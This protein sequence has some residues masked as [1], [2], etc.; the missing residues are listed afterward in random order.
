MRFILTLIAVMTALDVLWWAVA[1]RFV[2]GS[3]WQWFLGLFMAAQVCTILWFV[4]ARAARS[5]LDALL[6]QPAISALYIWHFIGLA[7]AL[8]I[9]LGMLVVLAA[10]G[11]RRL[12]VRSGKIAPEV[13]GDVCTRRRFIGIAAAVTPPLVTLGFTGLAAA[14]LS[15]FRV[16]R[17]EVPI[18]NLPRDLDG[19]SIAQVSDIHVG[20]FTNG[21][22]LRRIV[23][24]TNE[25]RADLVLLTGDVIN[26]ALA[27]L[28]SALDAVRAMD[29]RLGLCTIE[30]NHDLI[31]DR[32]EFE[33]RVRASGVPF[34]LD[35]TTRLT[36]RGAPV[37][38][39]G[40]RWTGHGRGGRESEIARAVRSLADWREPD[41]FP[42]LMAHH[43]HAFDTAA[44]VGLPLTLSGHTHGG[45]LMLNEALGAG[46][47]IFRYWSGVYSRGS[48]RLVVSNGVGNWFPV[49]INAPA[50]IIHLTLRRAA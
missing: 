49:R 11:I 27:D 17:L 41:A 37:Q 34:L 43:P 6:P 22:V 35:Q 36:V 39:L 30:G 12:V 15:Q 24:A 38:L 50:E 21:R 19:M 2:R 23:E 31:E 14:Q 25:L 20:R 16:R 26:N 9:L 1:S 44:E 18:T 33:R 3:R 5:G 42:I 4:A 48:S 29:P 10:R 7:L 46:P 32:A 40:M 8:P 28:P 13:A 47:A 45:Q